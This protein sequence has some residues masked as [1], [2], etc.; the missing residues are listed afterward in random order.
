MLRT[1]T[2]SDITVNGSDI[3]FGESDIMRDI[4]DNRSDIIRDIIPRESDIIGD[5]ILTRNDIIDD[6]IRDIT[7]SGEAMM[8]G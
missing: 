6:I 5:I 7:V 2:E 3:I 4:I 8:G 1:K